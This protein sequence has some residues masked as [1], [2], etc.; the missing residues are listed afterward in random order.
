[1]TL[2]GPVTPS[3]VDTATTTNHDAL[4]DCTTDSFVATGSPII[5]GTNTGQHLFVDT[6]GEDCVTASIFIQGTAAAARTWD[7][8]VIQYD[9]MNDMGGPAG[10]LQYFTEATGTVASFNYS[11][12]KA[13]TIPSAAV[14]HLSNQNYDICFRLAVG[15]CGKCFIPSV[16]SST[17]ANGGSFGLSVSAA[18]DKTESTIDTSCLA[19]YLAIPN[20]MAHATANPTAH[21]L[22]ISRVC[23]R[24]F[25]VIASTAATASICT[26]LKPIKLTFVTDGGEVASTEAAAAKANVNEQSVAATGHPTGS[27]GFSLNFA[28]QTICS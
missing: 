26:S 19:D 10:C 11:P 25:N 7:I 4:G 12:I 28:D 24:Q 27:L 18:A 16:V 1:M 5:C 8:Q 23:G 21:T 2:N 15:A 6:N 13:T 14:V 20:G 17:I 3:A 22:G 9:C